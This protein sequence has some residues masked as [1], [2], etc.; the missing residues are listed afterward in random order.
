MKQEWLEGHHARKRFGQN[1][2]HDKHWIERIVRGIDPKPGDALVEIGPGQAAITRY[3]IAAA[4]HE[5]AVEI[6][7]DLAAFLRTQF[8][9]E[10]LSLIEE[11]ALKL[12][13]TAVLPEKR[14]RIIGNLPYNISSPLL[15]ELMKAADRV[16]DQHFMLQKEV[17]DH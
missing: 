7:R 17:V 11:D 8:T 15:F 5:T 13:W 4:G 6:D 2:L 3:V 9:E 12:D 1:F 14:L 10:E 16:I